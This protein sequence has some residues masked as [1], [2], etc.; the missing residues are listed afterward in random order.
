MK[1]KFNPPLIRNRVLPKMGSSRVREFKVETEWLP[2]GGTA[3]SS[4]LSD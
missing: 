2:G 4:F 1:I 3:V